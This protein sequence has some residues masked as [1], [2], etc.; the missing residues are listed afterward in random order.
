MSVPD[1]EGKV[2]VD[3]Y[4]LYTKE[5]DS[6]ILDK[7]FWIKLAL[8]YQYFFQWLTLSDIIPPGRLVTTIVVTFSNFYYI[9]VSFKKKT[10]RE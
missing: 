10:L 2:L 9:N 5:F 4:Q 6:K 8:I 3:L 1:L 7:I